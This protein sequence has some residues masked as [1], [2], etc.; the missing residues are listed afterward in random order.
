MT[1]RTMVTAPTIISIV[2]NPE[3]GFNWN[4]FREIRVKKINTQ[5]FFQGSGYERP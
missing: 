5:Q 3:A 1:A 4:R 2:L